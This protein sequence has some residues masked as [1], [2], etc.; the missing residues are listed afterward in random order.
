[1]SEQMRKLMTGEAEPTQLGSHTHLRGVRRA[2]LGIGTV[3][4]W[5]HRGPAVWHF[6][7]PPTL[8]A[9]VNT[10]P[11]LKLPLGWAGLWLDLSFMRAGHL[12]Y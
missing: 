2:A 11:R 3:L 9:A 6:P 12:F 8:V 7:P 1:M 5:L 4:A 10:E